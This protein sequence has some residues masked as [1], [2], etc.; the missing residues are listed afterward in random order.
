MLLCAAHKA[1][2]RRQE[3]GQERT[4][5]DI[6]LQD[7]LDEYRTF[8]MLDEF[9]QRP[10]SLFTC[11]MAI[12]TQDIAFLIQQCVQCLGP[13]CAPLGDADPLLI[14]RTPCVCRLQL[15]CV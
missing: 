6:L 12:D 7:T 4:A 11:H 10:P 14:E 13:W 2:E 9:L 15:L 5:L 8:L 1:A 3:R